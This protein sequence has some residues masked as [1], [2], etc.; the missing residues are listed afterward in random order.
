MVPWTGGDLSSEF[1]GMGN[2]ADELLTDFSP[3]VELSPVEHLETG[4]T[5]S[6]ARGGEFDLAEFF[7]SWVLSDPWQGMEIIDHKIQVGF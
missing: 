6:A 5:D 3:I 7:P 2:R 1:F 4:D